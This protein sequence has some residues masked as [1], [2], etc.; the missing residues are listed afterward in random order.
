MYVSI[1]HMVLF[2]AVLCLGAQAALSDDVQISS[3]VDATRISQSDQLTLTVAV[4]GTRKEPQ[5]D[6]MP[7][8]DIT[9]T[10]ERG[11]TG[12]DFNTLKTSI[13]KTYSYTLRPK[14][15]GTFK[16][17]GASVRVGGKNYTTPAIT[18]QVVKTTAPQTQPQPQ[19]QAQSPAQTQSGKQTPSIGNENIFIKTSIDKD[20]AYVGEQV[21]FVFELYNRISIAETEYEPPSTTGFW[22]VELPA[23]PKSTTI[24][25][26]RRYY[27]N[28]IK[29]ALFPT[30]AG[31]RTVG[32][33]SL[34]FTTSAGFSLLGRSYRLTSEPLTLRVKPLPAKGK[35]AD[36]SGVV[37]DFTITAD[38]DNTTV[39]VGEVVT[40]HVSVTGRGN[41]DLVTSITEPDLSSF[42]TYDPKVTETIG[43]SGF[44]TSGAKSWDY[45]IIPRQQGVV[46]IKPFSLSFF[47]P[48]DET[49][50][51][52]AT[53]PI[54]L[55][56]LAGAALAF[57]GA[58]EKSTRSDIEHLASDIRYIKP[59]KTSL[60]SAE[61]HVYTRFY[62]YL[63]Y[64]VPL[65]GFIAA[66]AVKKR[67]DTI[68]RNTGLKR[69]LRAWKLAQIR[70]NEASIKLKDG[71]TPGFC[72]YLHE[73][74]TG[75]LG[76]M[77]NLDTGALTAR[78]LEEI[79]VKNGIE[80]GLGELMR[81]KLEMCDFVRFASVGTGRDA[82]EALLTEARDVITRLR[83]SL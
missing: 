53:E 1:K 47:N 35:P 11:S 20:E 41:L 56:V 65:A 33:A 46:T 19:S 75:Y 30:T 45:V 67:R 61:R 58:D 14:K 69:K 44:V 3:S 80:E 76:D 62:F 68:E 38:F 21:T 60:G 78:D 66:F 40:I 2:V 10:Y 51:T 31:E 16:V 18:V 79:M 25:N 22:A 42:R 59:E 23:I 4:L 34:D 81:K 26:N 77:L 74:I 28:V 24:V 15:P 17:S 52:V 43:N 83:D 7:E 63:L 50:H 8:F 27:H 54:E 39:K 9:G 82:Q 64:I 73:S 70:L 32:A 37:G 49:Y 13:S 55:K 6:P 36:F 5:L 72:G 12:V 71:D 48:A 57:D 29:T